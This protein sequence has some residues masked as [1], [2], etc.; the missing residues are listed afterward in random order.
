[1]TKSIQI[2]VDDEEYWKLLKLKDTKQSWKEFF[3]IEEL[4]K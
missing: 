3:K 1:M 4:V 2:P